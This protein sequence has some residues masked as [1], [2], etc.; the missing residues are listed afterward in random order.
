MSGGK[1]KEETTCFKNQRRWETSIVSRPLI[2]LI[3]LA[4]FKEKKENHSL[5]EYLPHHYD[6]SSKNLC[7]PTWSSVTKLAKSIT[8]TMPSC[9]PSF[10]NRSEWYKFF[11]IAK[12]PHSSLSPSPPQGSFQWGCFFSAEA[13]WSLADGLQPGIA[14]QQMPVRATSSQ[15]FPDQVLQLWSRRQFSLFQEKE[16][17]NETHLKMSLICSK[18]AERLQDSPAAHPHSAQLLAV[19]ARSSHR[20]DISYPPGN[21]FSFPGLTNYFDIRY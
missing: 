10:L 14:Q 13:N 18:T 12:T 8:E 6:S 15:M 20:W 9:F 1:E 2:F 21:H 3:R 16:E 17:K 4:V 11:V 19:V 5:S 7:L